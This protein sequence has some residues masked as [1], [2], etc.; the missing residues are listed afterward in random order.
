VGVQKEKSLREDGGIRL[1]GQEMRE[2]WCSVDV[3]LDGN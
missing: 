2:Q 1:L 3:K